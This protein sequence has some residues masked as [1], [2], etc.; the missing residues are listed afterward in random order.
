[1]RDQ[2]KAVAFT[3]V[4]VFTAAALSQ[5]I[6]GGVGVLDLNADGVRTVF[7]AGLAAVI[8]AAYNWVSPNDTR[9]GVGYSA[10]VNE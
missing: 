8:T 7:A 2:L 6:A 1:M 3:L 4:K 5:I 9:Y 10:N